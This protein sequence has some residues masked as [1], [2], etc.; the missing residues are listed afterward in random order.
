MTNSWV[1]MMS[2][3]RAG[4]T[5]LTDKN[6]IELAQ[7][8]AIRK[9]NFIIRPSSIKGIIIFWYKMNKNVIKLR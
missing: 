7:H 6:D 1:N 8:K 4:V 5:K 3:A 2:S 9:S